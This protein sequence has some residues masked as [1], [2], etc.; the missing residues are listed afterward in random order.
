MDIGNLIAIIIT[1]GVIVFVHEFGHF[2]FAKMNRIKVNEFS[3]GMGPSIATWTR[4]ETDYS[5]RALPIG[6]Y[7]LMEGMNEESDNKNAYNKKSVLARLSVSL[8]GPVFNF[9][10]AFL[11]AV[12]ISHFYTIDPPV[13]SEVM[14]NSAASE[15]GFKAGDVIVALDGNKIY[16]YR[17]ITLYSMVHDPETPVEITYRRD[18]QEKVTSLTRKKDP[19]SGNYYF[20]FY[21]IGREANGIGEE[22]MYSALE[23]RLQIKATLSSVKMLFTGKA[24]KDSLMGPVGIGNTMNDIIEEAKEN[25]EEKTAWAQFLVVL[26]NVINFAVL[27]SANLGVMNLLPIPA[28]DGGKI[29]F[30]LIEAISGKPVPPEKEMVVTGIGVALLMLLM[31]FVFFNDLGNVLHG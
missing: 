7:C 16:N 4:G 11:F 21:S 3:I 23:V 22:V 14:E 12:V 30:L 5:V 27:L 9:I 24:S 13:L 1:F 18:G 19:E 8:A 28:L 17:E 10:L 20:G 25:T 26:L 29:M 2:L 31:I 6:G 15:A